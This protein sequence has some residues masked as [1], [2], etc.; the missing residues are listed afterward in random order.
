[1]LYAWFSLMNT[2]I[3]IILCD[4]EENELKQI[5]E[6]IYDRLHQLEKTANYFDPSSELSLV[7]NTAYQHPVAI[8]DELF[9][10]VSQCISYNNLTAGYFDVTFAS[11]NHAADTIKHITLSEQNRTISFRKEGI[12]INLSGYLKGYAIE[13]T[14][15]ILYNHNM[16]NALINIGNS[17]VLGLGNHPHGVG[18]E[19]GF[20]SSHSAKSV[21]LENECLTTS[22][23]NTTERKHIV[24]PYSHQYVEGAK[25]ISVKTKKA[26]DGEALSTGLF[27][28]PDSYQEE[29][30]KN[31]E[32]TVINHINIH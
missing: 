20:D 15:D 8:S 31:F 14:R 22:G 26:T 3:D 32:A 29:I 11:E 10:L 5:A 19:V 9:G 7:N 28:A 25:T 18:W 2:R 16:A 17:S 4:R 30:L 24:S 21:K 23:N 13:A 27:A 1:M 12:K 6:T